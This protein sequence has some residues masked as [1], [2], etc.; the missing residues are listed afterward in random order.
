MAIVGK[1]LQA[2]IAFQDQFIAFPARLILCSNLYPAM[3]ISSLT[4]PLSFVHNMLA[5][6]KRKM[7]PQEIEVIWK[8]LWTTPVFGVLAI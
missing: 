4:I 7:S 5:G 3:Q 6:A 1:I 2:R 8:I